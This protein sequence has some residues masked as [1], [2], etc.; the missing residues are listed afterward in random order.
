[1]EDGA[2]LSVDLTGIFLRHRVHLV[3]IAVLLVDDLALAEDVVQD[4]FLGLHRRAGQLR[5]PD[6][7]LAYLRRATVNGARSLLRRRR[8]VRRHLR[9]VGVVT[10][11]GSDEGVLL[12]EEH[13][14]VLRAVRSLPTRDQEVLTLRYWSGLSDAEIADAL[15]VSRSTVSS[16]ASRA[17]GKIATLIG[18]QP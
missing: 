8:T 15:Q 18:D 17:L 4:A 6:A 13:A 9:T 3:H 12:A 11:P 2:P 14:G 1:M 7:A 5:D 16:T 10:A